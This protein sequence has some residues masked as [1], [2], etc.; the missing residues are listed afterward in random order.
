VGSA[1]PF[2]CERS[3][4][5]KYYHGCFGSQRHLGRRI[6]ALRAFPISSP[7]ISRGLHSA[8]S[9]TVPFTLARYCFTYGPMAAVKIVLL[10]LTHVF[11]FGVV[12]HQEGLFQLCLSVLVT[13][14]RRQT[15]TIAMLKICYCCNFLTSPALRERRSCQV[16]PKRELQSG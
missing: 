9:S 16:L 2:I 14:D 10:G 8:A 6:T 7:I 1:W 12:R 11:G 15:Y 13:I 5:G 3:L 4:N